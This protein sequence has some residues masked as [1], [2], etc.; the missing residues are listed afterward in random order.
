MTK[1]GENG[2]SFVWNAPNIV[3]IAGWKICRVRLIRSGLMTGSR[4][5][6]YVC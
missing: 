6:I 4:G 5:G 2:S 3:S 1:I